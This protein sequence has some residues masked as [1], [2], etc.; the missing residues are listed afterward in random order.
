MLLPAVTG[1]GESVLVTTR[2]ARVITLVEAVAVLLLESVS[3]SVAAAVALLLIVAPLAVEAG[4][5]T[6]I[7][8]TADSPAVTAAFEK[9]IGPEVLTAQPV[10]VVTTAETSEVPA[11]TASVTV[12]LLASD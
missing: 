6:T 7:V 10:P 3:V 8:K 2:S 5:L 11:G 1:S 4:T 9:T 12:T